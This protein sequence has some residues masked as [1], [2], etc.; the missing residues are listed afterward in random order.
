MNI[1]NTTEIFFK[2]A[3][4]M[5]SELYLKKAVTKTNLSTLS[6][7]WPTHHSILRYSLTECLQTVCSDSH[8]FIYCFETTKLYALFTL[9]ISYKLHKGLFYFLFRTKY[10]NGYRRGSK[11]KT[12]E[13]LNM[14]KL[15]R[16]LNN[17]SFGEYRHI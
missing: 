14:E 15:A 5:I 2:W 1:L 7:P 3:T 12:L 8:L 10:N 4:S 11:C 17:L 13:I 6:S 16:L 9:F